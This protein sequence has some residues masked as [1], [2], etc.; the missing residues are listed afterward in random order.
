MQPSAALSTSV[1]S[2]RSL[3][4]RARPR[5]GPAMP[6][7]IAAFAQLPLG[8]ASGVCCPAVS[9]ERHDMTRASCPSRGPQSLECLH[10]GRP[11]AHPRAMACR[12]IDGGGRGRSGCRCSVAAVAVPA[13]GQHD[14]CMMHLS[15]SGVATAAPESHFM[16]HTHADLMHAARFVC[17]GNAWPTGSVSTAATCT[18]RWRSATRPTAAPGKHLIA[19]KACAAFLQCTRVLV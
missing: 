1:H 5:T 3:P 10:R 2:S 18:R 7:C 8:Y 6:L 19:V 12:S 14:A 13:R 11:Q 9:C 4:R 17:R 15:C 16:Q